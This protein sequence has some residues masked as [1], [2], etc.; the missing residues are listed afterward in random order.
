M[1]RL[2]T[3]SAKQKVEYYHH[4]ITETMPE[5][6]ENGRHTKL[7]L[8]LARQIRKER[9]ET[10]LSYDKL[11]IKYNVSKSAIADIIKGRTW[12]ETVTEPVSTILES[13]E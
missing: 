9:E 7:N 10:K 13:E 11:A 5:I 4:W 6:I 3:I 2:T 1:P 8:E 12:K